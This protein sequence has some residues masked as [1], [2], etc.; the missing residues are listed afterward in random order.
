METTEDEQPEVPAAM[1]LKA[2]QSSQTS[3]DSLEMEGGSW[4][5]VKHR[6]DRV[7]QPYQLPSSPLRHRV[8]SHRE[9]TLLRSTETYQEGTQSQS[10]SGSVSKEEELCRKKKRRA[11]AIKRQAVVVAIRE[12]RQTPISDP[13]IHRQPHSSG[14]TMGRSPLVR[15]ERNFSRSPLELIR[16]GEEAGPSSTPS[17]ARQVRVSSSRA[18][19]AIKYTKRQRPG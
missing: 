12:R 15:Q 18:K 10:S 3:Q 19:P 1:E 13:A 4:Q 9:S 14:S 11:E 8:D 17:R 2:G 5:E 7:V 16:E 6:H